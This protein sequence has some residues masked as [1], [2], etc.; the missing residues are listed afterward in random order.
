[1]RYSERVDL[2]VE[3]RSK[4]NPLTKKK[5]ATYKTYTKIPCNVNRLSRERTQLEFG[6][7]AKDVSVVRLPKQLKFEPTHVLLKGRKYKV[8]DIRVYDHSTSLFISE[9]LS[10]GN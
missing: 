9:V 8:M 1:M 4:Y 5:E 6:E 3:E 2:V 7:M 10:D